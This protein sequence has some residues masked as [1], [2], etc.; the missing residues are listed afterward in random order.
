MEGVSMT[1]TLLETLHLDPNV[2]EEL[3]ELE[4]CDE[5]WDLQQSGGPGGPTYAYLLDGP[6]PGTHVHVPIFD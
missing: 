6:A 3:S 2:V 1:E 5:T 4:A